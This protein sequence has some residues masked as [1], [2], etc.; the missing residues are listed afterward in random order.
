MESE[1]SIIQFQNSLPE[2]STD[3]IRQTFAELLYSLIATQYSAA[4]PN[5]REGSARALTTSLLPI[6]V[7]TI[8]LW[9]WAFVVCG[10]SPSFH[11]TL[12]LPFNLYTGC[13]INCLSSCIWSHPL[14]PVNCCFHRFKYLMLWRL[15]PVFSCDVLVFT[16]IVSHFSVLQ[17]VELQLV[18]LPGTLWQV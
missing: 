17:L 6:I 1:N 11:G 7:Q 16:Q 8:S 3:S 2:S 12:T 13:H 10:F 15:R 14:S 5:E 18:L 9:R 4:C